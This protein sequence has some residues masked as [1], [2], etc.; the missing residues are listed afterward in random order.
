MKF[1]LSS[2]LQSPNEK[3][4]ELK[5]GR[6]KVEEVNWEEEQAEVE[7]HQSYH[8]NKPME[9]MEVKMGQ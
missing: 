8:A 3:D 9:Q 4:V 1:D 6:D 5:A 7:E 2:K